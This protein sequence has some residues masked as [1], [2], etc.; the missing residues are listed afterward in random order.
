MED[1]EIL[2]SG[3]AIYNTV[4]ADTIEKNA[5]VECSISGGT[6]KSDVWGVI[7]LGAGAPGQT[8][9]GQENGKKGIN[10]DGEEIL[11]DAIVLNIC[12]LYTSRCV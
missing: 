11:N 4:T 3:T 2:A 12:L 10:Y 1:G 8:N 9:N 5:V 6:V 7:V